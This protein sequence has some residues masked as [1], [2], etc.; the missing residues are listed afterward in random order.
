MCLCG[1]IL[2]IQIKSGML[3]LGLQALLIFQEGGGGVE[4]LHTRS[5]N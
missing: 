2:Y 1:D 5:A 3:N 4:P